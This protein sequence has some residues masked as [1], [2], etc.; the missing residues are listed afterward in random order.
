M[1]DSLAVPVRKS[2][3]DG[4]DEAVQ[5]GTDAG[6]YG[7]T[8]SGAGS[9]LVAISARRSAATVAKAMAA[10]LTKLGNPAEALHPDV[11]E[12]GLEVVSG[13]D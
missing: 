7:V 4:Y 10:T 11:V 1:L 8:I 6:A 2:M 12:T 9:T 13:N 3:I 5:A